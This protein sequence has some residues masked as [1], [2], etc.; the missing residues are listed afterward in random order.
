[1]P[2][3]LSR[4]KNEGKQ[5]KKRCVLRGR[6]D[7]YLTLSCMQGM[8]VF[9][10]CHACRACR[11]SHAAEQPRAHVTGLWQ[12]ATDAIRHPPGPGM[13]CASLTTAGLELLNPK[14]EKG[15]LP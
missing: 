6:Y 1:M 9:A 12:Y 4:A 14:E 3:S 7:W 5:S 10:P 15:E 11:Y 8:Q 13:G 2:P